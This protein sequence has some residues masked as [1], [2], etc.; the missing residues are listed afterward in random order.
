MKRS[1][2]MKKEMMMISTLSKDNNERSS[3]NWILPKNTVKLTIIR[4]HL[5]MCISLRTY[6]GQL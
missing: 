1:K 4:P 6:F 2:I 3:R 5:P